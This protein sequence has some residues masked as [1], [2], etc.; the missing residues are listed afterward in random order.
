MHDTLPSGGG[1]LGPIH[2]EG[3]RGIYKIHVSQR[4]INDNDW[5]YVTGEVLDENK[6]YLFGFGQEFWKASGYDSE[7]HWTERKTDYATKVTL[8]KGTYFLNFEFEI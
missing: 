3:D 7:G 1:T 5:S 2:V 4:I 6:N 8:Q